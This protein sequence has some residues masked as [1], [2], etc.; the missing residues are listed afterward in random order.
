MNKPGVWLN[1]DNTAAPLSCVHE[2]ENAGSWG[3]FKPTYI[4]LVASFSIEMDFLPIFS[5]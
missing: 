2:P 3:L 1:K 5:M 4:Y